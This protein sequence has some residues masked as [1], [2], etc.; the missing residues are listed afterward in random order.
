MMRQK[1]SSLGYNRVAATGVTALGH[2]DCAHIP[3]HMLTH[4]LWL[5]RN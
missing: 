1:K 2:S 5:C 4:Y 3:S